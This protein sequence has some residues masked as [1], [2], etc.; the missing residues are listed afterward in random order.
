MVDYIGFFLRII[1]LPNYGKSKQLVPKKG[2]L[3]KTL[4]KKKEIDTSAPFKLNVE[5]L[6]AVVDDKDLAFIE[7][8]CGG[9]SGV[10]QLLNTD[11][12]DGLSYLEAQ[13][14]NRKAQYPFMF[15]VVF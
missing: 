12:K 4:R 9:I 6:A 13:S 15:F 3:I 11:L 8:Q 2:G 7:T 5:T 10:A 14:A 1:P